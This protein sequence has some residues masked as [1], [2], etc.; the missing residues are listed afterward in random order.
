MMQ[1][2][3]PNINTC[4]GIREFIEKLMK[5]KALHLHSDALSVDKRVLFFPH[6]L[7]SFILIHVVAM[8][9]VYA[10]IFINHFYALLV[11]DYFG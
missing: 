5:L 7:T 11:C 1:M 2:G 8:F 9:T 6:V 4:V 10:F 3:V